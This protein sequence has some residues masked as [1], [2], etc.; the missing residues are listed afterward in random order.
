MAIVKLP[1]SVIMKIAAGEV[2]TGTFAVV[3][4]LFEN[5]I[6]AKSDKI[7][8]EI[9]DGGKTYIKISDNGVGMSEEDILL[10]VQP[11]TTSKIK[12]VE[13]LYDIH[14][15]G[16][17]GEALA[18][19]SRVS[20]MK[21]TSKRAEDDL[22]TSIEFIGSEPI[23]IKKVNAPVGT[24]IE[25]KD[26]FFN[27]PARRKFLKSAAVE[28]RM[29]TEIIEK[30][31]LSSNLSIDYIKDGNLVYSISKNMNLLEKI[32]IIFPETKKE[33]FFEINFNESWFKIYGFISHPRI[34]RNNRTAQIFFVNNRYIKSGDLFAVFESGY[35]EMLESRKHPYGIIFFDINPKEVDVNVHPQ[36]LEVKISESRIIYNKFK[37]LIRET[38]I[39]STK[40]KITINNENQYNNNN[41]EK[42]NIT[43]EIPIKSNKII[44]VSENVNSYKTNETLK[45]TIPIKINKE[46]YIKTA[47]FEKISNNN[48]NNKPEPY[49][50][51]KFLGL[52]ANRY[53]VLELKDSI[54]FI[55][56]HAAHERVIYEDL[57]KEFFENGNITTQI[58]MLPIKLNIDNS[59]KE[60]LENN[61]EKIRT[62]GFEI[63]KENNE[64]YIIGTPSNIRISNPHNTVIEI[65]DE[66][67][68]E[69]IESPERVFDN[70]IATMSCRAAVKT[71]DS[72]VGLDILIKKIIDYDILTC[73]HGRPISMELPLKKLDDFFERT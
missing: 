46:K 52:V 51:Y 1:E 48:D 42:N 54:Q 66:L 34:T 7:V 61:M 20:R 15:Y 26:L 47:N 3:K 28:G 50:Y 59:R 65:L 49:I 37:R 71:G 69:G 35:G 31:I 14:T 12:E 18:A 40:F 23:N 25:V 55:D 41:Y 19:I 64:Y 16:F 60:I 72:P 30:F 21:I 68:L 27:V 67:R 38:L 2:V 24:T 57:K 4:E 45:N 10:S 6:D 32:N 70:V 29:I 36:K 53:I 62:L 56:F 63:N 73:P 44:V 39:N 58:L 11:H 43:Y 17:R 5:S 13:D 8:V 9:I 22:A 33:D